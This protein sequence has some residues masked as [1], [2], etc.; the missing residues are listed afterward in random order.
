MLALAELCK[1][2]IDMH[3]GKIGPESQDLAV[4]RFGLGEAAGLVQAQGLTQLGVEQ[5]GLCGHGVLPDLV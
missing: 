4:K 1:R 3:L 5:R 2:T